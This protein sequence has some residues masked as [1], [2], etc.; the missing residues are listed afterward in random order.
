MTRKKGPNLGPASLLTSKEAGIYL[1]ADPTSVH[2]WVRHGQLKGFKTP[3]AHLRIRAADL[4]VFMREMGMVPPPELESAVLRPRVLIVDDD[5]KQL[6]AL[7]KVLK[8]YAEFIDVDFEQDPYTALL[9]IA[10]RRPH[11]LLLDLVMPKI[12]GIEMC[13]ALK[14]F[15]ETAATDIYIITGQVDE[16]AR[17][18]AL[19]AG[20][21]GF[22]TK[23]FPIDAI[24]NGL[25]LRVV[26]AA[27]K[28]GA[29]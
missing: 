24:L 29:D 12:D 21:K 1:Q 27:G 22:L 26:G 8:P 15:P 17:A 14:A 11:V 9:K 25:G 3:G 13:R 5:R 7:E 4:V 2:N 20:A 19:K 16:Q 6:Q 18:A 23:P 10:K 28:V